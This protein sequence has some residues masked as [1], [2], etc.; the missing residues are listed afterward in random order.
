MSL[1]P[2]SSVFAARIEFVRTIGAA[3]L[4]LS[5]VTAAHTS[6]KAVVLPPPTIDMAQQEGEQIAVI[7]GGCFWGIQGVYQHTEGVIQAM[8]GY[9]GGTK[10][11]ALYEVVSSGRTGH[12]ESVQIRFNSKKIS[13]G[14][15]LQ[16]FFSVAH[17]PTQLNRQG[18]DVGS[19][20]R[21]AI[22]YSNDDQKRVAEAYI[23]QLDELKVFKSPIVTRIDR[24]EAFYPAEAYHQ[25]YVE[26]HPEQPY[27][28]YNDLPKIGNLKR[29]MPDV[30]R[31]KPVLVSP[32]AASN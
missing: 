32:A 25:D 24:L 17:D 27:I 4:L 11:T 31:E 30:Y 13:Y 1:I 26:L 12:A 28:V 5:A 8:S 21:T 22:F 23:K 10:Q 15:I 18:P 20:Y 19:Q 16:I 2:C 9:S 14:K 6:E 29:L 3:A 7:A